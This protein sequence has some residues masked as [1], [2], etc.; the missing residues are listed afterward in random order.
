MNEFI[1]PFRGSLKNNPRLADHSEPL[2]MWI[3]HALIGM[4]KPPVRPVVLMM[5][6]SCKKT[7]IS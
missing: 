1:A 7:P 2:E 5:P 6:F 3:I 4:R